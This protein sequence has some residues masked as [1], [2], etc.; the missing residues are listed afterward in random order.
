MT[1]R[2]TIIEAVAKALYK[3]DWKVSW[4]AEGAE[5]HQHYRREAQVALDAMLPLIKGALAEH[6]LNTIDDP[7]DTSAIWRR[8]QKEY[9]ARLIE[10]W[11]LDD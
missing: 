4:G 2:E 11:T 6:I 8:F 1:T 5:T 10:G 3:D 9:A 7:L